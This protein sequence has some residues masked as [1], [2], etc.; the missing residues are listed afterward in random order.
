MKLPKEDG[1]SHDFA[2]SCSLKLERRKFRRSGG[3]FRDNVK[4]QRPFA[5]L[6]K[7]NYKTCDL[8]PI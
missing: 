3:E 6:S 7:V 1:K 2:R 4:F 5:M 8:R